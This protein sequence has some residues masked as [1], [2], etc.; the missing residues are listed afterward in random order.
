MRQA[1]RSLVVTIVALFWATGFC[2]AASVTLVPAPADLSAL[3]IGDTISIDVVLNGL[4]AGDELEFLGV[5]VGFDAPPLGTATNFTPGTIVPDPAGFVGFDTPGIADGSFDAFFTLS[6][7]DRIT[8]NGTFF[9]FDIQAVSVGSGQIGFSFADALRSDFTSPGVTT[10]PALRF[11][12]VPLPNQVI[13]GGVL[14]ALLVGG[15]LLR[16]RSHYQLQHN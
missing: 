14:M 10:G 5:T 6:G 12:V 2:Q 9:S 13:S 3:Q 16:H 1:S 4:A 11:T 15:H 7:I 8:T